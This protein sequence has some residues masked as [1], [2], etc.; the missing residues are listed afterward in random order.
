MWS[1]YS[2]GIVH[3]VVLLYNTNDQESFKSD[4]WERRVKY[5]IKVV[6]LSFMRGQQK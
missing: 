5:K 2:I 6:C 4:F 1:I 3:S